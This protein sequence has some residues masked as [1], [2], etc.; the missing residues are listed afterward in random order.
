MGLGKFAIVHRMSGKF[1]C[2]GLGYSAGFLT[3]RLVAKRWQTAGTTREGT[4]GLVRFERS[5]PLADARERLAETT[6][7]LI[8]IPPDAV[9]CPVLDIHGD[10]IAALRR[11]RWI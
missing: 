6:H 4:S 1:F 5:Q 3:H 11:L 9:G 2:F 10:D 7:L 8:S